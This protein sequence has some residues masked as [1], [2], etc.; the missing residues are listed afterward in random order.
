MEEVKPGFYELA[1]LN[2]EDPEGNRIKV[3]LPLDLAHKKLVDHSVKYKNLP[4][5]QGILISPKRIFRGIR[6]EEEGCWDDGW[7]YV[8]RPESI[9]LSD[10][11]QAPLGRT[12]VYSVYLDGNRVI[13]LWRSEKSDPGDPLSPIDHAERYGRRVWPR[14]S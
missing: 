11:V 8:G 7:C 12:F 1:A 14:A 2:P 3:Y 9:W 4:A 6:Q 5:V 10:A 13:Y